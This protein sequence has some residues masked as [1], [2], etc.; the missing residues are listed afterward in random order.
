VDAVVLQAAISLD[1]LERTGESQKIIS[2]SMSRVCGV[3]VLFVFAQRGNGKHQLYGLRSRTLLNIT[4]V[5]LCSVS[6]GAASHWP[7]PRHICV[8]VRHITGRRWLQGDIASIFTDHRKHDWCGSSFAAEMCVGPLGSSVIL[9]Q[10]QS[11]RITLDVVLNKVGRRRST[12]RIP[13]AC[14]RYRRGRFRSRHGIHNETL[15]A[16]PPPHLEPI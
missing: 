16:Q 7:T 8:L 11:A 4:T 10:A 2:T 5:I 3:C 12:K 14:R 1:T 13:L 15:A 6:S 9:L